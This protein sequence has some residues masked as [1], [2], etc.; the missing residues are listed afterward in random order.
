VALLAQQRAVERE[1][2]R[3][4]ATVA[5]EQASVAAAV[6]ELQQ[7]VTEL[8]FYARTVKEV[9]ASPN[10]AEIQAGHVL[11]AEAADEAAGGKGN[12]SRSG[13]RSGGS[14]RH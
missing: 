4:K 1:A 12:N 3:L 13:R 5:V 8:T 14:R 6:A 2:R 7:Q 9:G 10:K 11:V